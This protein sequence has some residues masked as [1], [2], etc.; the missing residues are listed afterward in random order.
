M[1]KTI[2]EEVDLIPNTM[3]EFDSMSE[4]IKFLDSKP[5]I[6]SN[7]AKTYGWSAKYFTGTM[8]YN[9]AIELAIKGWSAVSVELTKKLNISSKSIGTS[10]DMQKYLSQ[11]GFQAIV[12]L[13]LNGCP[14][15]M[16]NQKMVVKKQKIINVVKSV[17]FRGGE[18][19]EK[20][21]NE[22]VKTLMLVKMLESKGYRVNLYTLNGF[23]VNSG[24]YYVRVKV[25]SAN[26]NLNISKLAFPLVHPS[27]LR[28]LNFRFREIE[29]NANHD[30]I[31]GSLYS[32]EENK[33][34]IKKDEI[35]VPSFMQYSIDDIKD[36]SD[37]EKGLSFEEINS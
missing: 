22:S 14:N 30:G 35:F 19:V 17:G 29:C 15:N 16:M 36:L 21:K 24:Y 2:L 1:K 10:K 7:N 13:Y 4:Y 18:S 33:L 25:K 3:Y 37:I 23:R 31:G 8:N 5:Q 34:A 28:R 12:P 32:K 9:E 11:A 20:I 6:E 27:M 26:E